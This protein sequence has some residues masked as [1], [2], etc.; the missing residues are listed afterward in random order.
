MHDGALGIAIVVVHGGRFFSWLI[1]LS[2]VL[3]NTNLQ[4]KRI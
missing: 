3:I 2:F 1:M 4:A